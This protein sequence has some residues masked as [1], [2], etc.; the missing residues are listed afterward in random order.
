MPKPVPIPMRQ[1]IWERA[2]RGESAASPAQAFDLSPR[3]VRH[4]LKRARQYGKAGLPPGYRA[5]STP[6][7]AYPDGVRQAALASRRDH[8]TWGAELIRVMLAEERPQVAWP[9]PQTI[10]RWL[11]ATDLA[12]APAGRR[13][14]SSSSY[15]RATEPHQTWQIDASEH[16]PIA[17]K[18]EVCWLRVVDEATGSVLRTDVFPPRFLDPGRPPRGPEVLEAF[19]PEVGSPPATASRQRRPL[20]IAGG[21]AHRPGLLAG[22]AG[23]RGDGQSASQA[24]GQRGGRTVAGG[25]QAVVRA[26]DLP[27]ERRVAGS[28][29]SHGPGAA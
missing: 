12:P 1:K 9:S 6:D 21:P 19:V 2:A 13:L 5:P 28:A 22:G 26:L 24:P 27:I 4:L 11:R 29:G 18:S 14:G 17:D 8:P 10:R 25:R 16:I 3:T 7:H 23:R 15:V 20:G